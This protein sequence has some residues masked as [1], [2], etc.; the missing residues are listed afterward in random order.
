M[1]NPFVS[2]LRVRERSRMRRV[3]NPHLASSHPLPLRGA[4]GNN[5]R[6]SR[7]ISLPVSPS[8]V[9]LPQCLAYSHVRPSSAYG[10]STAAVGL[11]AALI[12]RSTQVVTA[13]RRQGS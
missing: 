9:G 13:D 11:V 6:T 12:G 7:P 5:A 2:L 10:L 8:L 4:R 3:E 1:S